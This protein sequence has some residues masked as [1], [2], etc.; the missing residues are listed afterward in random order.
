MN[1]YDVVFLHM[2][3]FLTEAAPGRVTE[4]P[5]REVLEGYVGEIL[6]VGINYDRDNVDKPHICVIEKMEKQ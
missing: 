2:Q 1:R 3:Q 5:E 6:A 4:C